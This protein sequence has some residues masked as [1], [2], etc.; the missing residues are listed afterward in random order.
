MTQGPLALPRSRTGTVAIDGAHATLRFERT[1]RHPPEEVWAA[2]TQPEAL[3]A[4]YMAKASIDG[5]K[6]GTVDM[7]TGP[8]Q[9]H[10]TGRILVWDPPRTFE[11]EWRVAPR[12]ELPEGEDAV[13][14]WEL[15]PVPEGTR[16]LLTHR[17]LTKATA[18]GF[19]PGTHALLDRLE[20][21]LD[22]TPLPAFGQ[23]YQEVLPGYPPMP[24]PPGARPASGPD[25][26]A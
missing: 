1:L 3:S 2:L 16:L 15:E 9:F 10:V 11:H 22:R 12:P 18:L 23:R 13:I 19:A 26:P 20:A 8:S 25:R 17:R 5:R 14:R 6:G 7:H 21:H 4:W 24:G